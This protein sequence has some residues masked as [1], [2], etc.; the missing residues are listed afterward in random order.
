MSRH[1]LTLTR[2][3]LTTPLAL[4]AALLCLGALAT[5]PAHAGITIDSISGVPNPVPAA[6]AFVP[7]LIGCGNTT[8]TPTGT[9]VLAYSNGTVVSQDGTY[10]YRADADGNPIIYTYVSFPY[11]PS[12]TASVTYTLT[13][14]V[15]GS[16][17]TSATRSMN[18]LQ[19]AKVPITVNS[20]TPTTIQATDQTISLSV[21]I[22]D[23]GANQSA[24]NK[25]AA[26]LINS[27]GT[28]IDFQPLNGPYT[29]DSNGNPILTTTLGNIPINTSGSAQHYTIELELQDKSGSW[30]YPTFSVT[31][32]AASVTV[33]P[34][35]T[36]LA[37][38][39]VAGTIGQPVAL[40]A[41]LTASGAALSGQTVSF[42][43]DGATVGS[44]ATNSAG[45]ASFPYTLRS[46]FAVGGHTIT[47]SF[48]GS[49]TDAA[50]S[51]TGTLT[52]SNP[53]VIVGSAGT[54][55][56]I[57]RPTGKAGKV[58]NLRGRVR[59]ISDR[60]VLVGETITF[61]VDG[62]AVGT[63]LTDANGLAT[64]AYTVP[65]SLPLGYHAFTVAFA[66]DSTYAASSANGSLTVTQ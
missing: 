50:S 61:T 43:V 59:R 5:Q 4:L 20:I 12:P 28:A 60:A 40:S 56:T 42:Q 53:V 65:D 36:S 8:G 3:L 6:G 30:T 17:G 57:T 13:I 9:A 44:S 25:G 62:A 7:V 22:T 21:D 10:Y 32:L 11:D 34:T 55:M 27:S 19:G 58:V 49:S 66:G 52:A 23:N 15:T 54:T 48:A 14:T 24:Y 46:G 38:A 37:A 63:G 47:A 45:V 31:Q 51:G 35:A 16:D 2:Q 33:P 41:T 64:F 26:Y 18:V 29:Q 39:S 1:F